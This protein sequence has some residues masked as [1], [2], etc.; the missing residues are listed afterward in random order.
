MHLLTINVEIQRIQAEGQEKLQPR[1]YR[2][3]WNAV[4]S[5][6][7]SESETKP[8]T[9]RNGTKVAGDHDRGQRET[10]AKTTDLLRVLCE[11]L[12]K[13]WKRA[14]ETGIET[15][16][17]RDHIN[18]SDAPAVYVHADVRDPVSST[19]ENHNR[20]SQRLS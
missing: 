11:S 7:T 17:H 2:E 8:A 10:L 18:G 4:E 9:L 13:S 20:L 6:T 5:V 12:P 1:K 16:T 19:P 3:S 14:L 15:C